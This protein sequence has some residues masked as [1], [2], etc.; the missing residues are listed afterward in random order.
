MSYKEKYSEFLDSIKIHQEKFINDIL[1][2]KGPVLLV[3]HYDADGL[4]AASL[5]AIFLKKY[6]IP[7]HIRIL[8]QIDE[9]SISKVKS[10]NYTN[11]LFTD[12]GSGEYS[13]IRDKL[14]DRIIYI[15]D[16][17]QPEEVSRERRIV[18]I[19]PYFHNINGSTEV[20]SAA[21]T[22]IFLREIDDEII[23]YSPLAVIGA[24]GDRQDIGP[25]FSL[26][27]LNDAIAK[28]AEEYG[29]LR[30]EIGLRL[31]S[32]K[33]RPLLKA[34]EYTFDPYIPGLSGREDSC[35]IF[36][37]KIGIDP[38][39][40][41][42]LKYINELSKDE[43][44]KLATALVKYMLDTGVSLK[45]AERIFGMN[46][47]LLNE[48]ETSLLYDAREYVQILNSCGRMGRCDVAIALCMGV[49]E[50]IVE[51]ALGIAKQ[52]R[53]TLAKILEKAFKRRKVLG[54]TIILNLIDIADSRVTGAIASILSSIWSE[55][56]NAI[57]VIGRGDT[58]ER[59]KISARLT[60]KIP[61]EKDKRNLGYALKIAAR[62][63]G[64]VGGGHLRAGGALIPVEKMDLFVE[65]LIK[66]LE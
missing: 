29:L 3:S 35:L 37:K 14:K 2:K 52:Y 55:E 10:L 6:D 64:G 65:F 28:E 45:D 32:S 40:N 62:N 8:E 13:L 46:Y 16:H 23:T 11:I 39:K 49:R 47:Y 21:L 63:V 24:L 51:E 36:L 42:K 15:L 57:V 26:V 19:N 58:K 22:Y 48:H 60:R 54:S 66:K 34:L 59:V 5:L 12:L 27:G 4:T 33:N 9:N 50:K 43:I 61:E 38:S 7:Y 56:A 31:A 53:K 17:H 1:E 44:R 20:S 41:G 30:K 25:R 18:E